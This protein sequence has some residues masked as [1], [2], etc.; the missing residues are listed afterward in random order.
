MKLPIKFDG[1]IIGEA[2]VSPDGSII[3]AEL[4]LS[5]VGQEIRDIL[6]SGLTDS[7]SIRPNHIPVVRKK[8]PIEHINSF[9]NGD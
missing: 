9:C 2:E 3:K 7:L 4:D 1:F 8:P 6:S 5:G